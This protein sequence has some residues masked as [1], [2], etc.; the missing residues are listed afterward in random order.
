[1]NIPDQQVIINDIKGWI[2]DNQKPS[3][4]R[5]YVTISASYLLKFITKFYNLQHK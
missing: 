3:G 1:M 4:D 2:S 5:G